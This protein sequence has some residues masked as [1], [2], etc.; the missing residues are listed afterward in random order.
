MS[1][2]EVLQNATPIATNDEFL[3]K[4]DAD[5][6]AEVQQALEL[7]RDKGFAVAAFTPTELRGADPDH[8][9]DAMVQ[10]G[11]GAIDM[12]ATEPLPDEEESK[13]QS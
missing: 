13:V 5:L 9:E 10:M 6:T 3:E 1:E 12:S 4:V 7:L 11:W 2:N 8:I